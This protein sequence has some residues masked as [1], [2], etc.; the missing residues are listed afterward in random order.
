MK[1]TKSAI[2]TI[3]L[4]LAILPARTAYSQ[5]KELGIPDI[6]NY[7]R[8]EYKGGPQNWDIDQDKKGNLYFANGSGLLKFD[9]TNWHKFLL[10][11]ASVLQS[12]KTDDSGRIYVGG[13]NEFGYFLNN[14]K[15]NLTYHSLSQG[16]IKNK[17]I[18]KKINLI[19]KIHCYQD[20]VIFQSFTKV[21]FLKKNK[22]RYYECKN[23]FQFSFLVNNKLYFQDKK[24]GLLSYSKEKFTPLKGTAAL[25]N[26]EI[27]A[28]F[29]LP[30]DKL[31]IATLENGLF[32]YDNNSIQPWRT[33]ANDYLQKNSSLGGCMIKN[34][35]IVFN[36]VLNGVI[37]SDL[38][39]KIIQHLNRQKGIQNNT[40]LKSFVDKNSNLWLGLDNGITFITENSPFTYFDYSYNMGTVYAS[41]VHKNIL[42]VA[43]NQGLFYQKYDEMRFD[44]PFNRVEGTISQAWNIQ[45]IDGQLLCASNNGALLIENNRIAKVLNHQG[46]FG[47]LS[48]PNHPGSILGENYNGFSIFKKKNNKF[49]FENSVAGFDE[50]ANM[51]ETYLDEDF[52]WVKK[53]SVLYQM[54]LSDDL[55][56]FKKITI[57]PKI[58]KKYNGIESIQK[59]NDKIYFQTKNH[60]FRYSKEQEIFFEDK[61]ISSLF[62]NT[63]QLNRIIEDKI[64]NIWYRHNTL[65]GVLEKDK[66]GNYTKREAPFTNL[67]ANLVTDYISINT[68]NPNNVFIGLTEGL[69][70]FDFTIPNNFITKPKVYIDS[71]ST[72]QDTIVTGNLSNSN[73]N[74]NLAYSANQVKFTFSSPIYENSQNTAY[75][76]KLEPFEENW[77]NWTSSSMKEYTNLREGD[78]VMKVKVKNSYGVESEPAKLYFTISPPWY[79][80]P[81]AYLTYLILIILAVYI[82]Y[83]RVKLKIRKNKYYETIEQRRLYLEK[84]SKIRQ[85]QFELEKEIEKLKNDKLQ[86]Q[87][88]AKD[89]ELVTNSLQVVK[90]NKV[91]NGIL[92]KVKEIDTKNLDEPMKFQV[93]KLNKSIVKEVNNDKSWKDLEKHI[94]NVHFDFLKRLKE[95]YPTISPRE[96]DLSTYLLM[97]MST[98]EIAEIMNISIGG[99]E[100]A[101][102]RLR[103]KLG[104]NKKENLI[105]FL[106][107]I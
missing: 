7:K 10:P 17:N 35:F 65:L 95:K 60:F 25:N 23:N 16:F 29:P 100:L 12:L 70:H 15:G 32:I 2:L 84:E 24:L 11:N 77:T 56:K 75:S 52:L 71:F 87:I 27:W 91:L 6:R 61:K 46:Y 8:N 30:N 78:Y 64:G 106:M 41:L 33:E 40:V 66:N 38:N 19:W 98:K 89:K 62:K 90:K 107:S 76:Y 101:R 22:L 103:K 72:L 42:Y 53:N 68:V 1:F 93:N 3:S 18:S 31:I 80:H 54:E 63:H 88:L 92:Q 36:T 83:N 69:A 96:L 59:L 81:L 102:Y 58:S 20:E 55:K 74:Y 50:A 82:G 48:I 94:K 13:N 43:T 86:I 49:E 21:F 85:G 4:L 97:N 57:H 105:G 34:K 51:L 99:V 104:L 28:I 47:F 37:I 79:R 14:E 45:L 73:K 26:S 5:V 9:G 39:G 67:S 44:K